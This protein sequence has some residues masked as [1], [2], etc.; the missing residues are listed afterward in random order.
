MYEIFFCHSNIYFCGYVSNKFMMYI[1]G[2]ENEGSRASHSYSGSN[3]DGNKGSST[4]IYN[5]SNRRT[6]QI[7]KPLVSVSLLSLIT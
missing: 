2:Y 1:Y 5:K 7:H 3:N 4:S 6:E